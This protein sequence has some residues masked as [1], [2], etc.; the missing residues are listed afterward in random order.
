[1]RQQWAAQFN[2][3]PKDPPAMHAYA[4]K[5]SRAQLAQV[6]RFGIAG[7]DMPGHE[8]LSEG[9]IASLA[10]WLSQSPAQPLPLTTETH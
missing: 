6:V 7:T 3:F 9:E 2:H 4:G 10:I 5:H 8:F 1:M